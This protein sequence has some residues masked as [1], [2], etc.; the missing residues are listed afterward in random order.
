MKNSALYCADPTKIA[1]AKK[2][3]ASLKLDLLTA[4]PFP[5]TIL[6][7]TAQRL[8]L[9]NSR[10]S[11][12]VFVD[13]NS[14]KLLYRLAHTSIKKEAIARA[15]GLKKTK[16]LVLDATAGFGRDSFILAALGCR[17]IMVER[18]PIIAALLADGLRRAL[19]TSQIAPI[20]Q[21]MTLYHAESKFFQLKSR[22]EPEA[23]YL[24]PMY[25]ARSKNALV[26][27]EMRCLQNIAGNDSDSDTLLNWALS[28]E[29]K[30]VVVKRPKG[31]KHLADQ[32]PSFIIKSRKHRFDVY[33]IS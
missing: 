10:E 12:P 22:L 17:V 32:Q 21:R 15:M 24:D 19:V 14:P 9:R 16:P 23:I 11:S 7:L 25:P 29:V 30:R 31:A 4:P 13:F 20:C 6:A 26:K 33:L 1:E 27:K 8:E 18:S 3:A 5:A 28:R 2:L